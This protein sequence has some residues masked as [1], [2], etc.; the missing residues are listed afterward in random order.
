MRS[1]APIEGYRGNFDQALDCL[2]LT[3]VQRLQVGD[4]FLNADP[5]WDPVRD[6]PRFKTILEGMGLA[7]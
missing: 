1:E 5:A 3:R 7:D 2:E 4:I 6:H